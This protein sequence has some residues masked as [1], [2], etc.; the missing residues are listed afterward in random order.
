MKKYL[1][2][3]FTN[4]YLVSLIFLV[5]MITFFDRYDL[6]TQYQL[7]AQLHELEQTKM[8]YENEIS[9]NKATI[10]SLQN[11]AQELERFAREKYLM[12]KNNEEIFLVFQ[13]DSSTVIK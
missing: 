7:R 10:Y 13:T 2:Q 8:F 3:L 1:I 11:N 4:K 12:K 5:V 9:K 6:I